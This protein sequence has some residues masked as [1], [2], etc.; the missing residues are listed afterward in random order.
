MDKRRELFRRNKTLRQAFFEE[1]LKQKQRELVVTNLLS[2]NSSLSPEEKKYWDFYRFIFL[3][4]RRTRNENEV[5][6]ALAGQALDIQNRKRADFDSA[7]T[8][9]AKTAIPF[10][11][12]WF[13]SSV[14]YFVACIA[15]DTENK[16]YIC[17]VICSQTGTKQFN[18]DWAKFYL[19]M[20]QAPTSPKA[21]LC[22]DFVQYSINKTQP[23]Y[24][25]QYPAESS[26]SVAFRTF[27]T[28]P[29]LN[30]Y[31]MAK[32]LTQ[33]PSEILSIEDF[34]MTIF[35]SRYLNLNLTEYL[36]IDTIDQKEKIQTITLIKQRGE[37]FNI[38]PNQENMLKAFHAMFLIELEQHHA[39]KQALKILAETEKNSD[40]FPMIKRCAFL[41]LYRENFQEARQLF[42][43]Y[44]N[45]PDTQF[46]MKLCDAWERIKTPS[47]TDAR[48]TTEFS[49]F[50]DQAPPGAKSEEAESAEEPTRKQRVK[51]RPKKEEIEQLIKC[52]AFQPL[53]PIKK[54][55]PQN[56]FDVMQQLFGVAKAGRQSL[57]WTQVG[58][59]IDAIGGKTITTGE[60]IQISFPSLIHPERPVNVGFDK[61]HGSREKGIF[62]PSDTYHHRLIT[63]LRFHGHDSE[64]FKL[65]QAS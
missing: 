37:L 43:C 32:H 47:Q 10:I 12:G 2:L 33:M 17:A 51:T 57:T 11:N 63:A 21:K 49:D 48:D 5:V 22:H 7:I 9:K 46:N 64:Q 42:A 55:I 26:F 16:Q 61:P 23:L 8:T 4:E 24:Q 27:T 15:A 65:T 14:A 19:K 53:A 58:L 36:G 39:S 18:T 56:A 1:P 3:P 59:F 31:A 60:Q 38:N 35:F 44:P 62:D 6:A 34:Y 54:S 45:Q 52:K 13:R 25:Q 29:I 20:G 41:L 28:A 40:V 50:E 30:Y